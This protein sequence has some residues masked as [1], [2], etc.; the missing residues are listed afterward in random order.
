[1][2]TESEALARRRSAA[3]VAHGDPTIGL[4]LSGGG[5]RSATFCLGLLRALARNKV[6]HRVDYLSTV[7]GGGY[8]GSAFGR[9]FHGG[10][11]GDA[12]AVE[13]GV[14][15]DRS[16][17]LWWLRNNGRFLT[18]AGA[19]D[20]IQALSSQLRGFL[21]T[22][23]EVVVLMMLVA[24]A[25]TAPHLVYS[26]LY[27]AEEHLPL[28]M[29]LWWWGLPLPLAGVLTAC[30]GY[31][32][33][34]RE[35]GSG[36]ATAA[37]AA[38]IGIYLA[39]H[40]YAAQA[41]NRPIAFDV[42]LLGVAA[43]LLLPA[44]PA[45][46][47]ARLSG[48]RRK[49]EAN[50]VR[51]TTALAWSLKGL[52]AML[53][54]GAID[55]LS[56]YLKSGLSA[57]LNGE[58]SGSVAGGVGITA[59][60]LAALR[61]ALP[62]LQNGAK[63]GMAKVSWGIVANVAGIVL[64]LALALFWMTIFQTLI[65]PAKDDPLSDLLRNAYARWA[66]VAAIGVVYILLNGRF[67]QQ[68][69][70]SS[71]H[72]FYRSRIARAYVSV[73]NAPGDG[74]PCPRFPASPLAD[75]T[76]EL[77]EGVAKVTRLLDG[78]DPC[79]T[80]YTPHRFGGPIHL[81]NCC[82]NQTVDDRTGTYNADR[83]GISLTVSALG[84]ETGTHRPIAG[85]ATLLDETTLAQWV[86]ISGAA[87]GSGMGS[88]TRPGIAAMSF[89][90]GLRLGYWQGNLTPGHVRGRGVIA[91]YRAMLREMFARFPGLRS[92]DWYLSDGGQF[93]NTGV[94]S[95]LKRQLSLIV[96]ADCGADPDFRFA[97][98]ENLVR[99][100]RIDY[101]T[102]IEFVDPVQLASV[103]GPA[104]VWFGSP[105]TIDSTPGTAHLLLAR[106]TYTNGNRGTMIVVKPRL[107]TD[108]PLDVAGYADSDATFPQQGTLN[109]FF[110]EAQWESYCELGALL[111]A[112]I[113]ATL[114][115][116]ADDWAWSTPVLGANCATL[117]PTSTPMS[118]AQRIATTVGTGIGIGAL[119]TALLAGWQAW[120][121]HSQQRVSL[122]TENAD[123]ARQLNGD[124]RTLIDYLTSPEVQAGTFD[125]QVDAQVN[126]LTAV[127]GGLSLSD[128]QKNVF[129]DVSELLQPICQ[130]TPDTDL[131]TQC[132][133]QAYALSPEGMA[134][135]NSWSASM[136][137]YNLWRDARREAVLAPIYEARRLAE[138]LSV[139]ASTA[140]PTPAPSPS[141]APA[142]MPPPL[143]GTA[144]PGTMSPGPAAPAVVADAAPGLETPDRLRDDALE[145][146][147]ASR[148]PFM[149]YTQIYDES[150]RA[151]VVRSLVAVRQLGIVAPGVENVTE[152]ARRD[153]RQSPF[154]WKTPTLL[155]APDG[156]ACA[157][158]L[159]NWANVTMP[160][161]AGNPARA[162]P[163][164]V[165]TTNGNVLELWIPR[166][167]ARH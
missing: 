133:V 51:Y 93:D 89:L 22:Q 18:P 126:M 15:N 143:T 164:P 124:T 38:G 50:R 20:L 5:I 107:A 80:G 134:S 26:W 105:N 4:A 34:G 165:R 69:N 44:A 9:L 42:I 97:D 43:F 132:L 94:Y 135:K 110:S 70:R 144:S 146:C 3:G 19:S 99:K 55:M 41:G 86:A 154:E 11:D 52:A 47:C 35:T 56:W 13:A 120:D 45:W 130:R 118:R 127:I 73:G 39:R 113:D 98:V 149:L 79:M 102:T 131:S 157:V 36:A 136:D 156:K 104:A 108:L 60:L 161:L 77:T 37:V 8:I 46:I 48:L 64:A 129:Q 87:V 84:V 40:A 106:I 167:R 138:Q 159:V 75:N 16:L 114:L 123:L 119:L 137:G 23:A 81:V 54:F 58:A 82:I 111:G 122:Q 71:L 92:D 63:G 65:F 10:T 85:S 117:T 83:K 28:S 21:A 148:Q 32:F 95:L 57:A 76:R 27:A 17:F 68:L 125:S 152:S 153:G 67:L 25:I 151:I 29:S 88:L 59:G 147:G 14:A 128:Q 90:S 30:Y 141:T 62:L 31:W 115:R 150:Q 100:A 155:Y 162:V 2:E 33:L 160:G 163:T 6:L 74:V 103:A 166:P 78:D 12:A 140:A 1:M 158:A 49:E 96:L 91:K 145:A 24:C 66:C 116:H 112:P 109:Q 121:A 139:E 72:F 101:D 7:S 142:P 61:Y 53:V